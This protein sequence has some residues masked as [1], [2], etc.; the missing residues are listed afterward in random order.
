M[1]AAII[2]IIVSLLALCVLSMAR[3]NDA[4]RSNGKQ[5]IYYKKEK[6]GEAK[7]YDDDRVSMDFKPKVSVAGDTREIHIHTETTGTKIVQ[8]LKRHD[9]EKKRLLDHY[10]SGDIIDIGGGMVRVKHDYLRNRYIKG[11]I[12]SDDLLFADTDDAGYVTIKRTVL[13]DMEQRLTQYLEKFK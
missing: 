6:Y 8:G 9:A 3:N 11:A 1:T 5:P 10:G 13:D 7:A 2:I 4:K 12:I